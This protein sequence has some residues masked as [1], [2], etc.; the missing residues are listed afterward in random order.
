MS[1]ISITTTQN[2]T[3]D[4]SLAGFQSRLLAFF[5]DFLII[6]VWVIVHLLLSGLFFT[7]DYIR[8]IYQWIIIVP[9]AAFYTLAME[10]FMNGQTPGKRSMG[11]RVLMLNGKEPSFL[12][13]FIRWSLRFVEIYFSSGVLATI[14]INTTNLKQRLADIIAGTVLVKA[15]TSQSIFVDDLSRISSQ[16]SYEPTYPQVLMFKESEMIVIKILIDRFLENQ[17]SAHR[18]LVKDAAINLAS[19][20]GVKIKEPQPELFLKV[21]IRDFVLLTR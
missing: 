14:M 4:Y 6:V 8:D 16:N 1:Y 10:Y 5:I 3:I 21:L 18:S 11:I 9:F 2:V 12:V 7:D 13:Y 20:M 19:K 15:N 17:N